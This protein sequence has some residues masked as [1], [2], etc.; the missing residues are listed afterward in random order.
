MKSLAGS[1]PAH[2][3]LMHVHSML[4]WY[5]EA[6]STFIAPAST[7]IHRTQYIGSRKDHM[8]LRGWF[9]NVNATR[10]VIGLIDE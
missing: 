10:G 5:V 1:Q 2:L 8:F 4:N 9:S 6:G 3:P 7:Q